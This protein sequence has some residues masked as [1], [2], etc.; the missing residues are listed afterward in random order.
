MAVRNSRRA[1][2]LTWLVLMLAALGWLHGRLS[3][4]T[5]MAF[6]L[7]PAGAAQQQ[8]VLD[9]LREGA[10][11]RLLILAIEAE[12]T[13]QAAQLSE[14]MAEALDGEP[15][16]SQILNRPAMLD[17]VQGDEGFRYRYLFSTPDWDALPHSLHQR[18]D[19]LNSP[20]AA[21]TRRH[22]ASDPTA[23]YRHWLESMRG[24]G[25]ASLRHGVWFDGDGRAL[26]LLRTRAAG[27]E[28]AAQDEN[29]QLIRQHFKR[30]DPQ[31][32][33]SLQLGGAPAL[34]VA[35]RDTIQAEARVLSIAASLAVMVIL[36]WAYRSLR[37]WLL[38]A[39][40]LATA[41]VT[42]LLA[43]MLLFGQVHG[44][45]LAFGIT[46]IGV[47][48]D[49]PLHLFSQLRRG[50][51]PGQAMSEIWPTLRL[52]VLST[53]LGYLAMILSGFHGLM[54]L[55]VFASAG[56]LAAALCTR[57]L[58][59]ALLPTRWNG[60]EVRP[61]RF[62]PRRPRSAI[63]AQ[64]AIGL[65]AVGALMILLFSP[66][67]LWQQDIAALSPVPES[68]R[69]QEGRLRA[70]LG[71]PDLAHLLL[72]QG[73]SAEAVLQ[74]SEALWPALRQWQA[75]GVIADFEL[76]A[77]WLPSVATQRQRQQA[78]PSPPA[79]RAQLAEAQAG[80]LFREDAFEPFVTALAASRHLS[81]L[82]P[83]DLADDG[84]LRARIAP[85]L[86]ER[87]GQWW[88]QVPLRGVSD[89]ALLAQRTAEQ[90]GVLYLDLAAATGRML[91]GFRSASLSY[92]GLGAALIAVLLWW[93]L[94]SLRRAAWVLL[95]VGSAL[96]G[97]MALLHLFGELL[98]LFHLVALLLVLGIGLDYSLFFS[99]GGDDA[100]RGRTAHALGLCAISS[101]SVFAILSLSQLPVLHAIGLTV[102]LGIIS[103][104]LFA[105][106]LASRGS[107]ST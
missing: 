23:S 57:W 80:L 48:L 52:G 2:L 78:L 46:L 90:D 19:E 22:L 94:G 39:L 7:P 96:L 72:L 69:A 73:D 30:L 28:L 12:D 79:L 25:G 60:G 51:A 66:R 104:F 75:E 100:A 76:A 54:Q 97:T 105:W 43:V 82:G 98:S 47:A 33:A 35:S 99:R 13:Q 58:L 63:R 106:M 5:D 81:P 88:A 59:P 32:L 83:E 95:P 40:P 10:A 50:Q 31:G 36:L 18:L 27:M 49:Y 9:E 77:R 3:L 65:F 91:D 16:F 38:A 67:P 61:L 8:L 101:L 21:F 42:A 87:E 102:T 70:A 56:L 20:L 93:G 85:L 41:V 45:T 55:G 74:R 26:L 17:D 89:P 62:A 14:A 84:L 6:F 68:Q 37:L 53:A 86:F 24:E 103:S 4:N 107:A 44:I 34:A 1:I 92:L 71:V 11:A 15:G 29:I 64:W